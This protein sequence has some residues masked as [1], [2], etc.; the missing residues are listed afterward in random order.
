[1]TRSSDS[2]QPLPYQSLLSISPLLPFLKSVYLLWIF[3]SKISSLT[4]IKENGKL[5]S[6][7]ERTKRCPPVL[8]IISSG[9]FRH[10]I[11]RITTTRPCLYT[12]PFRGN[13]GMVLH[14][15]W[16]YLGWYSLPWTSTPKKKFQD[17]GLKEFLQ[18]I[19]NFLESYKRP[20]A[21]SLTY[22]QIIYESMG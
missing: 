14:R 7:R 15:I 2:R 11:I 17:T 13:Y 10:L 21:S 20:H 4:N 9:F 8:S 16:G 3:E 5:L 18:Y 22:K 19:C 12:Y 1:V 6:S